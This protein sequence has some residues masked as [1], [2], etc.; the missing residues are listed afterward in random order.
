MKIRVLGCGTSS[1]VPRIGNQ[2]GACDP[3]EP[4]NRRRRVSILVEVG[5]ARILVDTGPDLRE[6]LIDA[7]VGLVDAIVWTHDHADHCHGIDDVRQLFHARG[8]PVPGYARPATMDALRSRFAYAF[9]GNDGYPPTIAARALPDRL[10]F[11]DAVL[12]VVDQPHGT[13]TSAGLVF[14]SGGGKFVYAT[15][16]HA[17][18]DEMRTAYAGADLW[19][20]D[21][22]RR[23][24]H[25]THPHVAQ[26]LA[27]VEELAPERA[28][29]TH[30]DH[31]MD[32]RTLCAELPDH[33]RPAHDGQEIEL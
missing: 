21:A 20:I 25:P 23:A 6:Q 27:W 1:G 33:V 5:G 10:A 12:D 4:R 18:T 8:G 22:L 14:S 11:G 7:R 29:L 3:D 19:I 16:L 24:P 28:L 30:M 32:Y 17:M 26:V 2:W 15:D 31:S 9:A 13:I